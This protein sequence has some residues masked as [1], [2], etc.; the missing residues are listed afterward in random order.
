MFFIIPLL[1]SHLDRHESQSEPR[2]G[3]FVELIITSNSKKMIVHKEEKPEILQAFL[4]F[5]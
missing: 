3:G 2:G 4:C 1:N 5:W